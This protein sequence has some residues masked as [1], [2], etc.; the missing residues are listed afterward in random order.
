MPAH[1]ALAVAVEAKR[2]AV[3]FRGLQQ[4]GDH[5]GIAP[6]GDDEI[7]VVIQQNGL[8][9]VQKI[10]GRVQAEQMVKTIAAQGEVAHRGAGRVAIGQDLQVA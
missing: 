2:N 8:D 4:K 3:L 5:P 10:P 6:V 9:G 1:L 7:R